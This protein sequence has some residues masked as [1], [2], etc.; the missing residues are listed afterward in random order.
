VLLAKCVGSPS[1][2]IQITKQAPDIRTSAASLW[3]QDKRFAGSLGAAPIDLV[4]DG[5]GPAGKSKKRLRYESHIIFFFAPFFYNLVAAGLFFSGF[6]FTSGRIAS[7]FIFAIL[8]LCLGM[9]LSSG[10]SLRSKHER[11]TLARPSI[12]ILS[13]VFHGI[14]IITGWFTPFGVQLRFYVVSFLTKLTLQA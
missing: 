2:K 4:K 1:L 12:S 6:G 7:L 10:S 5:H 11:F 8:L 9:Q 3:N 14:V 13:F